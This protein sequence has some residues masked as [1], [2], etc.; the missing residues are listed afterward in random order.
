MGFTDRIKAKNLDLIADGKRIEL[1]NLAKQNLGLNEALLN[2]KNFQEFASDP[3]TFASKYNLEIDEGIASAL[4]DRLAGVTSLK[5]A[6]QTL[7]NPI[8][9]VGATLW[10]VAKA[11]YS[12]AD[13]KIAVAYMPV[14]LA[15][16][17]RELQ[18]VRQINQL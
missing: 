1:K 18:R 13:S 6:Q 12:I 10:A 11:S 16:E 4:H 15:T 3:K 2:E 7:V 8:D 9:E 5:E 17:I 14:D